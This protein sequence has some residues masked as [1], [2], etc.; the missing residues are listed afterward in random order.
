M[1]KGS[2]NVWINDKRK[3]DPYTKIP[4]WM[5]KEKWLFTKKKKILNEWWNEKCP[6]PNNI[7]MNE[8]GKN[9]RYSKIPESM[10]KW[11]NDSYPKLWRN[12]EG[13]NDH[14]PKI[15]ELNLESKNDPYTKIRESLMKGKW[16]FPQKIPA[17]IMKVKMT[18][19]LQ[20]LNEWWMGKWPYPKNIWMNDEM[21]TWLSPQN[22]WMND[23]RK[24]VLYT[25]LPDLIMKGKITLSNNTSMN[26][27]GKNNPY[28]KMLKWM[29]KGK[30]L[31]TKNLNEW[32]N[33]KTTPY[34]NIINEWRQEKWL[35]HKNR[36]IILVS[37]NVPYSKLIEWMMKEKWP[38][39]KNTWF[40]YERKNYHGTK[41]LNNDEWKN[42]LYLKTPESWKEKW[43]LHTKK[44]GWMIKE[45][46][47]LSQKYLNQWWK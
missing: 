9:K 29:M 3:N 10:M 39:P 28:P 46:I 11:K 18:L 17:W 47:I 37:N 19:I 1:R 24:N 30:W 36:G 31:I 34:L 23:E 33:E 43:S 44:I 2:K 40:N 35:L 13:E 25:K 4:E 8:E 42:E 14:Y 6:F 32:W 21:K 45:N 16:P 26:D 7:C 15:T 22:T 20:Y 38:F 12:D 5:M 41:Y 27:K